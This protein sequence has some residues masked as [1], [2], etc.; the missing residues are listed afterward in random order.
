[1]A[2]HIP[3]RKTKPEVKKLANTAEA[4]PYPHNVGKRRKITTIDGSHLYVIN[5]GEIVRPQGKAPH[6]KLI[7]LQ[8]LRHEAD[9][10]LEYRFTYY[11]L[12][13]KEGRMLNRWVFGQYSLMIP[14]KDLS[15][16]LKKARDK[17]WEGF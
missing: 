14:A 7:Y 15:V 10:R 12:S 5:E 1:M 9:N 6:N 3:P 13:P 16:L 8:K 2:V 11:M 4:P 17:G